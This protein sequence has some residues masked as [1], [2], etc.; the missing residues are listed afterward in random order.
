VVVDED[1]DDT[2]IDEG[3]LTFVVSDH[4]KEDYSWKSNKPDK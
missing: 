1:K 3:D 2:G 4:V